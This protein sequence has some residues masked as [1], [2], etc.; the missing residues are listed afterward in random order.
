MAAKEEGRKKVS[1]EEEVEVEFFFFLW[2]SR[3]ARVLQT[4]M[5]LSRLEKAPAGPLFTPMG[6][7]TSECANS[8]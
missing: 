3:R 4:V 7:K 1:K 8:E 5:P 6:K 2:L